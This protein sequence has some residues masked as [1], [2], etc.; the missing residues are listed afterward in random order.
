[1]CST[2]LSV[3]HAADGAGGG[4]SWVF[5]GTL[6]SPL[7]VAGGGG[8]A[9][10]NESGLSALAGWNGQ[11]G[12]GAI[13]ADACF[14]R[15]EMA[16]EFIANVS[17]CDPRQLGGVGGVNG[18]P[19]RGGAGVSSGCNGA[20]GSST[21]GGDAGNYG[22]TGN[23]GGGGSGMHGGNMLFLGGGS[24]SVA[25]CATDVD[26]NETICT[27]GEK[28]SNTAAGGVG[29]GGAGGAT[30]ALFGGGMLIVQCQRNTLD[31]TKPCE[32]R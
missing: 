7:F 32:Y 26:T 8:G 14:N 5:N 23:G 17:E 16:A 12:T 28:A 24:S 11:N 29:G 9:G 10:R 19:G 3:W 27:G 6:L 18:A 30:S 25:S 22:C 1:M 21:G 31:S 2:L 15:T 20:D 13:S 4:G